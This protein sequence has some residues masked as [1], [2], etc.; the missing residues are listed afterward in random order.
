M[1]A[2]LVCINCGDPVMRERWAT[3][4]HFCMKR[5]CIERCG[6]DFRVLYEPTPDAIDLTIYELDENEDPPD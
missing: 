6:P 3:G 2:N 1:E 5:Q 4:R